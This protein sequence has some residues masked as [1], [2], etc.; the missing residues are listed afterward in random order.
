MKP[1]IFSKITA[2]S[3]R[4]LVICLIVLLTTG[5]RVQ[6]NGDGTVAHWY[7]ARND[8]T[9]WLN[10]CNED[11]VF[12]SIDLPSSDPFYGNGSDL[13][14]VMQSVMDDFNDVETS[15]FRFARYPDDPDNPP[16]PEP[17]DSEF[18]RA[19]ARIRTIDLC[20]GDLPYYAAA[21]AESKT[22]EDV[23]DQIG[24]QSEYQSYCSETRFYS[25]KITLNKSIAEESLSG[26]VHTVAHELG[27]CVGLLHN[28]DTHLSIMSY[29]ADPKEIQRLQMDDKMGLT[30][31]YPKEDSYNDEEPTLGLTGCE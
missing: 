19:A 8:P 24:N 7:I 25:C 1:T 31:L 9:I 2:R 5:F 13:Q 11:I 28:H 14:D 17:G 12:D 21:Q 3:S 18:T 26:F 30:Y 22:N 4:L 16:A 6:L 29:V 27:H 20:F 23:C 15:F 10:F